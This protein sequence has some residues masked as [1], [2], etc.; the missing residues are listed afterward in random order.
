MCG[1]F[2]YLNKTISIDQLKHLS[3]L[4]SKRGP[5]SSVFIV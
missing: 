4:G 5:E 3:S 1:I 2:A